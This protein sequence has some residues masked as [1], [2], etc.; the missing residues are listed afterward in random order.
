MNAYSCYTQVLYCE[1][2]TLGYADRRNSMK[3]HMP[4]AMLIQHGYLGCCICHIR[5]VWPRGAFNGPL[6]HPFPLEHPVHMSLHLP[7]ALC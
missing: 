5:L 1:Q 2:Q 6:E 4:S 7:R 3:C